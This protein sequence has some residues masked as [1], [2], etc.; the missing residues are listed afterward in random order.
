[1]H[2]PRGAGS[3]GGGLLQ[4][5]EDQIGDPGLLRTLAGWRAARLESGLPSH[6]SFSAIVR[7]LARSSFLAKAGP[8]GFRFVIVGEALTQRLRRKLEGELVASDAPE[9]FGSLMATYRRCVEQRAPCYEFLRADFGDG[10]PLW[11][12]RLALPFSGNGQDEIYV[13]GTVLFGKPERT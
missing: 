9:V 10:Q 4:A 13:G 6:I 8:D 12:E 3:R 11:F 1:M 7:D 5:M 2:H